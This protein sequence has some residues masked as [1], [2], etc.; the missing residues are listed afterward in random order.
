LNL[1]EREVAAFNEGVCTGDWS[2]LVQLF[3]VDAELV[4]EGIAVGPFHG[5]E[6]FS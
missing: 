5:Y 3:A 4:F 1:L 2:A 6:R